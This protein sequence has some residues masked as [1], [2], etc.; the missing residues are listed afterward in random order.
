MRSLAEESEN[1]RNLHIREMSNFLTYINLDSEG[2]YN[3]YLENKKS[4]DPRDQTLISEMVIGYITQLKGKISERTKRP[5]GYGKRKDALTAIRR[6]I[7]TNSMQVNLDG[8]SK[9]IRDLVRG[10]QSDKMKPSKEQVA[11][12]IGISPNYRLKAM[13]AMVKDTYLRLD[14]LVEVRYGDIK[15]GLD[16]VD[17]FGYFPITIGKTKQKAFVIFGFEATKY[18][19]LWINELRKTRTVDDNTKIFT[20]VQNYGGRKEGRDLTAAIASQLINN[21]IKKLGLKGQISENG[22]RYFYHSQLEGVLNKNILSL[23][24]GKMIGD[25]SAHYSKHDLNEL[26]EIYKRNYNVL[27]VESTQDR[28]MDKKLAGVLA[29]TARSLGASEEKIKQIMDMLEIGA[30]TLDQFQ[31]RISEMIRE[32]KKSEK[33]EVM[34]IDEKDIENHLNHGWVF[35]GLTP[36]GRCIVKRSL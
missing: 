4:P 6:F 20:T 35:V 19:R 11:Q 30:L 3:L 21:Q 26:L 28:D 14:D 12:L 27:V 22:L 8:N 2:L 34:V 7:A 25:S 1:R 13:I 33:D 10:T 24:E 31:N 23:L 18:L 16:S 17:G 36:S 15:Q 5:L 9:R 29:T 32:T